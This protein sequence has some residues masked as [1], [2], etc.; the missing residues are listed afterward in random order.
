MQ[1]WDKQFDGFEFRHRVS[2]GPLPLPLGE[3]WGEGLQFI[4]R[5]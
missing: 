1:V 2:G 5:P 4:V 3:G